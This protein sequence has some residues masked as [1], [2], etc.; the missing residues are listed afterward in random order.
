[1][2]IVGLLFSTLENTARLLFVYQEMRKRGVDVFTMQFDPFA[3]ITLMGFCIT[4]RKRNWPLAAVMFTSLLAPLLTIVTSSL[5]T[6]VEAPLIQ[7]T[8]LVI[9]DWFDIRNTGKTWWDSTNR[10]MGLHMGIS[11]LVLFANTSYPQWTYSEAVFPHLTFADNNLPPSPKEQRQELHARIPG[12]RANMNCTLSHMHHNGHFKTTRKDPLLGNKTE[13]IIPVAMPPRCHPSGLLTPSDGDDDPA[14]LDFIFDPPTGITSFFFADQVHDFID[15]LYGMTLTTSPGKADANSSCSDNRLHLWFA[16][17]HQTGNTTDDLALLHC[18]PY[19][20]ALAYTA[21][22]ATRNFDINT[23]AAPVPD[24]ST[25]RPL[26]LDHNNMT[27]APLS[28]A[29]TTPLV[30]AESA[31]RAKNVA[32]PPGISAFFAA[33]IYGAEGTPIAD[34]TG[35]DNVPRLIDRMQHLYR[36]LVAQVL[37]VHYRAELPPVVVASSQEAAAGGKNGFALPDVGAHE[38]H[39]SMTDPRGRRRLVQ[40]GVATR[41]LEVLLLCMAVAA[42]VGCWMGGSARV[43]PADPGSLA[44]RLAALV[45]SEGLVGRMQDGRMGWQGDEVWRTFQGERFALGWWNVGGDGRGRRR[46]GI[47][48][49]VPIT[50]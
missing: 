3:N 12:V 32:V 9:Q 28:F 42:A 23:T 33:L 17:G 36:Q 2:V 5:Y 22:F 11:D 45:G 10:G 19:I 29:V 26:L 7:N 35:A 37:H 24:E 8:T 18:A 41:L 1:M 31:L 50:P 4:L 14:T 6:P 44:V 13:L 16:V 43:L 30:G 39:A 38:V 34:L 21:T 49:G 20:E 15:P 25:A 46:F 40:S 47:D 27:T 48:V